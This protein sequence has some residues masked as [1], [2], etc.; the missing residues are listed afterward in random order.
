MNNCRMRKKT[1]WVKLTFAPAQ[2]KWCVLRLFIRKKLI[3]T[4]SDFSYE[5]L[6]PL[7][8]YI[9]V[10]PLNLSFLLKEL[11]LRYKT[12]LIMVERSSLQLGLISFRYIVW[13]WTVLKFDRTLLIGRPLIS[14][15][16]YVVEKYK[17]WRNSNMNLIRVTWL[18]MRKE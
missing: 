11:R 4:L 14:T 2:A 16:K 8:K 1:H 6:F 15:V 18:S 10:F 17:F 7:P 9:S 5:I 13:V 3:Q 12:W